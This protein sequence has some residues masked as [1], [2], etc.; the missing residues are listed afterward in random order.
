M[1]I[2]CDSEMDRDTDIARPLG[3]SL[4]CDSH[5]QPH[6]LPAPASPLITQLNSDTNML[7]EVLNLTAT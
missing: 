6:A 3:D 5:I 1:F 4:T 7:W 2:L